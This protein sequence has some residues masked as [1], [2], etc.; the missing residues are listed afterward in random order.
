MKKRAG[1][2]KSA[3]K[4]RAAEDADNGAAI[5]RITIAARSS[6]ISERV[7]G[8]GRMTVS[9]ERVIRLVDGRGE[10]RAR[11]AREAGSSLRSE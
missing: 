3:Q 6:R 1:R 4:D 10:E 2:K 8:F 7:L 9:I 11:F 5:R